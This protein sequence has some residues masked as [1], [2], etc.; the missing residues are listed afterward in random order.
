MIILSDRLVLSGV[1][2]ALSLNHPVIGYRNIVTISNITADGAEPNYPASNLANPAT[3]LE[4]R[5]AAR[6]AQNLT[7]TTGETEE[8]DYIGIAKHNFGSARIPVSVE[9]Y[10]DGEWEELISPAMPADD[11][12]LL[13][14]FNSSSYDQLRLVLAEGE[15]APRAAVLYCGKLLVLERRIYVGHVPTPDAIQ[16]RVTSGRSE[17]GQ[18]L[19]R[20]VLGEGRET[21]VPLSLIS[22]DFFRAYIRPFLRASQDLPFFFGWRPQE[23]PNEIGFVWLL[24][25][26]QPAAV[27]PSNRIAFDMK[28][29]GIA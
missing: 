18:F 23:Y 22:P 26:P 3:H 5:A 15:A 1:E 7:I 9:A 19:G 8:L 2:A 14:R 12:P 28:L 10:I 17:S 25:N 16:T 24:D 6:E 27:G 21:S 29:G 4:W 20:I 11:A 13:Y